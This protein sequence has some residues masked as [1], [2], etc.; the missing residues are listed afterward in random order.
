MHNSKIDQLLEFLKDDPDDP[1]TLYA[2][3]LEYD[4]QKDEKTGL[5]FDRLLKD[6]PDY[7]ATYYHAAKFYEQSDSEKAKEIYKA[8]MNVA[9]GQGKHK[10]YNEL[11]NALNMLLDAEYD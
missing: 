2:L 5:Y 10:A 1:F 6:H 11:Q 3:A 8:G 7:L 4:K 9:S